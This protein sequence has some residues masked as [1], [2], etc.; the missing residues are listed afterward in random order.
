MT[1]PVGP[2]GTEEQRRD[3]RGQ[4]GQKNERA[5][6]NAAG[7]RRRRALS[8]VGSARRITWPATGS[9]RRSERLGCRR[10]SQN[11]GSPRSRTAVGSGSSDKGLEPPEDPDEQRR[12]RTERGGPGSAPAAVTARGWPRGGREHRGPAAPSAERTPAAAVFGGVCEA[13]VAFH[14]GRQ[15]HHG[16]PDKSEICRND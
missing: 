8:R 11:R 2:T 1:P 14:S 16:N 6:E 13:D 12:R 7:L 5:R 4:R 15:M 3:Q 9:Q 10:N